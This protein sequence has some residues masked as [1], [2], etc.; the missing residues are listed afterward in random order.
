MSDPPSPTIGM[1]HEAP[2][3]AAL[4]A[5]Y[6]G[7]GDQIEARL[8]R[9]VID[10]IRADGLLVEI[11]TRSFAS[12]RTKMRRLVAERPLRLVYPVAAE[13]WIVRLAGGGSQPLRRKSP[14]RGTAAD[15]F[16]EL[17]SFPDLLTLPTFS[18]EVL[19]IREEEVRRHERGRAW[20]RGGW[21]TDHRHLLEVVG[22][23][24][25]QSPAEMAALLPPG[26]P[27][28][29]IAADLARQGALTRRLAGQ[30]VYC[31]REMGAIAV[32]GKRGNAFLY[33]GSKSE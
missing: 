32:V 6:A 23:R 11:Q 24:L 20:R 3:H 19:L 27:E 25:F 1:L 2:L 13:K 28:P 10:I 15:V 31:L 8:G 16:A 5:W 30:M 12:I 17:V 21:V 9:Y 26:L 18:L 22:R 14:R 33:A 4:K 7:P 29:F